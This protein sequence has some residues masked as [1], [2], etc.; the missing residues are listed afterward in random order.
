MYH[1]VGQIIFEDIKFRGFSKFKLKN[2][3][4]KFRGCGQ[5]ANFSI[6]HA[7]SELKAHG[8]QHVVTRSPENIATIYDKMC[9][10]SAQVFLSD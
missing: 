5:P 3:W 8:A 4:K 10:D 2:S 1:T 6:L 7:S 9:D